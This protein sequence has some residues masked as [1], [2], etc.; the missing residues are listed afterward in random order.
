MKAGTED[1]WEEFK[2]ARNYKN[3]M[4]LAD[5]GRRSGHSLHKRASHWRPYGRNPSGQGTIYQNR[6]PY[7]PPPPLIRDK[8]LADDAEGKGE[9]LMD[10]FFPPP[11]QT[12]LDDIQMARYPTAHQ[13]N[14]EGNQTSPF[15][16]SPGI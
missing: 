11:V 4:I 6:H 12:D 10:T 5:Q 2:F 1:S 3:R 9:I 15:F 8:E 14:N 13:R 16:Q 7:S